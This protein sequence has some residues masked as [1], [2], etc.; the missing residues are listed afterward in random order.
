MEQQQSV[1][2][3]NALAGFVVYIENAY[4][5]CILPAQSRLVLRQASPLGMHSSVQLAQRLATGA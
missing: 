4:S 3:S 1:V 2:V 5:A